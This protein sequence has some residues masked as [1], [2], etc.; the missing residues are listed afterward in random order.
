MRRA[1]GW[2]QRR[3]RA[4]PAVLHAPRGLLQPQAR[5][6]TAAVPGPQRPEPR[7][8]PVR[9]GARLRRRCR[10]RGAQP[11][12]AQVDDH[13][14]G[15]AG[16]GCR[17]HPSGGTAKVAHAGTAACAARSPASC[18]APSPTARP[19]SMASPVCRRSWCRA[20]RS[21]ARPQPQG[22]P[23]AP[24]APPQPGVH[25]HPGQRPPPARVAARRARGLDPPGQPPEGPPARWEPSPAQAVGSPP[26]SRK[27]RCRGGGKAG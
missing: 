2:T 22:P 7:G 1:V 4:R 24:Q 3:R 19:A 23:G 6:R 8:D 14:Q 18:R 25:P 9:Q 20:R 16:Q 21:P 26:A 27:R 15:H 12:N 13:Q 11:P 10:S 17:G 5:P